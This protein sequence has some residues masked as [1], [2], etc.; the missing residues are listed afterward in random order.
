MITR[1][2]VV[3]EA[4]SLLGV[5]WAHQGRT[6]WGLDCLGLVVVVGQRLGLLEP[7]L[8]EPYGRQPDGLRL[9]RAADEHLLAL[10]T[11]RARP[12]DVV[13]I[14]W[15]RYPMHCGILG[16]WLLYTT[17]I[18]A[19]AP[20]G[21]VIEHRLELPFGGESPTPRIVASYAWPGMS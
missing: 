20:A 21:K 12:G 15:R 3:R 11:Q 2:D 19:F 4:R 13:L 16:G 6:Q 8:D 18:H 1:D 5:P 14:A 7:G 17:L 10:D 9:Q